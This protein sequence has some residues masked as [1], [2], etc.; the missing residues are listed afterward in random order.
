[1]NGLVK[2]MAKTLLTVPKYGYISPPRHSETHHHVTPLP[3][4]QDSQPNESSS[5]FTKNSIKS[6]PKDGM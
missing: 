3:P 5:A 1:M 6:T 4:S 2:Q